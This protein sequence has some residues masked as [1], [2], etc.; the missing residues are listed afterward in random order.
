MNKNKTT[1]YIDDLIKIEKRINKLESYLKK[2][3][4]AS[5]SK[6]DILLDLINIKLNKN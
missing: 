6:Q 1:K 4:D 3:S 5:F 2:H